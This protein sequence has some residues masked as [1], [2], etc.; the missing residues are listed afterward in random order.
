MSDGELNRYLF[1]LNQH[2]VGKDKLILIYIEGK[3]GRADVK[4]MFSPSCAPAA[5]AG[6]IAIV[7][8]NALS[9]I[10]HHF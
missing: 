5:T 4:K 7:N 8:I 6:N 1:Y 9:F 3:A 2:A 10:S